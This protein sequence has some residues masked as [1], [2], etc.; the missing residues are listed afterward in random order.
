M[1]KVEKSEKLGVKIE[2]SKISPNRLIFCTRGLS[3][4][5]NTM[6]IQGVR[7]LCGHRD[8]TFFITQICILNL[9]FIEIK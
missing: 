4:M 2:F 9:F 3:I 1:P 5:G 7:Q 8:F 6:V